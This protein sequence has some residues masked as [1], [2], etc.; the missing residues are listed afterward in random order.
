MSRAKYYKKIRIEKKIYVAAET[1][2]KI[3]D[4]YFSMEEKFRK[5]WWFEEVEQMLEDKSML[6]TFRI[7]CNCSRVLLK[8][9]TSKRRLL[10]M[11]LK[12]KPGVTLYYLETLTLILLAI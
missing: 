1:T 12:S 6:K 7:S 2:R 3:S 5:F 10:I 9:I 11:T 8:F 4:K